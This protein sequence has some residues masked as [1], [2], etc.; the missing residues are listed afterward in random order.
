MAYTYRASTSAGNAQGNA[1]TINVPTVVNGDLIKL[2]TYWETDANSVTWP[3]GF[4]EKASIANTG[5]FTVRTAYKWASSEGATYTLTPATNGKWRVALCA[6]YSGGAGSGDP[7]D[8]A[9]G[10]QGDG[11][12]PESTQTAPSI[13]TA[14]ANELLC[15]SYGNFGGTDPTA[16][17]GTVT[18]LRVKLGGTIIADVNR[19]SAG[20]TG[21]SA[22]TGQGTQDYA[23]MH[24]AWKSSSST[25]AGSEASA[26]TVTSILNKTIPLAGIESGIESVT[27]KLNNAIAVAGSIAGIESVSG[28][29]NERIPLAGNVVNAESATGLLNETI[30]L[31]GSV[32]AIEAGT[33][34]LNETIPLA[35][36]VAA[37]ESITGILNETIP[38]SGSLADVES[39]TGA[40]TVTSSGG[41]SG[42]IDG[43]ST[44]TGILNDDIPL[45]GSESGLESITGIL[46]ED[47]PLA[48]SIIDAETVTAALDVT[49]GVA[50]GNS[51][52][53]LW[54]TTDITYRWKQ[55]RPNVWVEDVGEIIFEEDEAIA[56]T[57]LAIA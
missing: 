56:L 10:S 3:T 38:L 21:T 29:L 41:L 9:S 35:G 30:P 46:N 36:S 48:G 51:D 47:I 43:L 23:G 5:A 37:V 49:T 40:L 39:V 33:G 32:A 53:R 22:P 54:P 18:N 20:A 52:G 24:D 11:V 14:E 7:F 50:G 42:A 12:T 26:E 1:L 17:T 55:I 27:S 57:L 31:A 28:A 4:V 25:M 2:V 15:F 13:N 45:A 16:L 19:V 6:T 44:V 8:T 34:V